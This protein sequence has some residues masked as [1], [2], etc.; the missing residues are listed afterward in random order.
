MT[1]KDTK[2]GHETEALAQQPIKQTKQDLGKTP[3]NKQ[4]SP[5]IHTI[6]LYTL[7]ICV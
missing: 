5:H 1:R 4:N 6:Y 2:Q 3:E 7:Y